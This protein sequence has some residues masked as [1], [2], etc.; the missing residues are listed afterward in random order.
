M[1]RS[2]LIGTCM[3]ILVY[4]GGNEIETG[5]QLNAESVRLCIAV[6]TLLSI[7]KRN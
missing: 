2:G 7:H 3:N 6:P 5:Y 4:G 1:N